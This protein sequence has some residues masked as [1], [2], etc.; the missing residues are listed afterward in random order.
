MENEPYRMVI[1]PLSAAVIGVLSA[2]DNKETEF[3]GLDW[4]SE[5]ADDSGITTSKKSGLHDDASK[6]ETDEDTLLEDSLQSG[7]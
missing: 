3:P 7:I 2:S 4:K 5:T 6:T 1:P